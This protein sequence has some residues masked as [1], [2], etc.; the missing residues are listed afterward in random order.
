[1]VTERGDRQLGLGS[2]GN[3]LTIPGLWAIRHGQSTANVA[4]AS[5]PTAPVPG[6]DLDVE[7]SALGR[8][9]ADA[10]GAWLASL[11]PARRPGLVVTSPYARARQTWARMARVDAAVSTHPPIPVVV[12]ERLRD[13][14]MGVFELCPPAVIAARDPAEAAR[15]ETLGDW[16]YRPPGGES[17]PDVV[18]RVGVFLTALDR[19][20]AGRYPVL[21][22]AH[23]GVIAAIRQVLDG[24]PGEVVA[25]VANASISRWDRGESGL[26]LT[27]WASAQH[28]TEQEL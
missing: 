15:R 20:V 19:V 8:A 14:E 25:P 3:E 6:R 9:Q 21:I 17:M 16:W 11:G 2:V 4:F 10:V 23:D 28:L 22:V 5:T 18:L 7:L 12:D 13:R 26:R 27:D 1:M 24:E